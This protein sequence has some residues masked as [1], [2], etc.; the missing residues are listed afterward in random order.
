MATKTSQE[1][2]LKVEL[3]PLIIIPTVDGHLLEFDPFS[4]TPAEIDSLEGVSDHA[5]KMAKEEVVAFISSQ[6]AKWTIG[7]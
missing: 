4:T 5:K 7:T 6:M 3:A 1:D 2:R